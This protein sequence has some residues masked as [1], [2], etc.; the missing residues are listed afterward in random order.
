[1]VEQG[2]S[3]HGPE[4]EDAE[5]LAARQE[6]E[7]TEFVAALRELRDD[8]GRPSFRTMA[9][10]AHYSHT[11]LSGVLSGGRLPSLELT[12]AF[13]RACGGDED[14]WRSRWHRANERI[15]PPMAQQSA[16]TAAS[17]RASAPSRGRRWPRWGVATAGLVGAGVLAGLLLS[18]AGT[19]R[20]VFLGEAD[21]AGY[22]R[23]HGFTGVSLDGVTAYDWHC[24]RSPATRS[25]MSVIEV[26]RWQYR[27][28]TATARYD[29]FHDPYSWQCWDHV[30]VLGRVDLDRYCRAHGYVTAALDGL[31]IDTWHCVTANNGRTG[32]DED[33]ACRWQYGSRLL[34]ANPGLVDA[35]WDKWD[36]WG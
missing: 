10:A 25:S 18:S 9:A 27:T 1:M 16:V 7:I 20:S 32:I 21:L 4:P 22:C 23:T 6:R 26:C 3:S 12:I 8:A 11:A 33:S 30:V 5:T 29:D 2:H 24:R 34:V 31:T 28:A 35:P 17:R 13:V 15:N 36:C 19:P 14:A